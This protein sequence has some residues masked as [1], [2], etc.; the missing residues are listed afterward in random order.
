MYRFHPE[1]TFVRELIDG[2]AIGEVKM[3]RGTFDFYLNRPGDIRLSKELAGGSLMDV[4]CYPVNAARMIVGAEPVAVQGSAVWG[5]NGV[6][7]SFAG[8][9]EFPNGVLATIESSFRTELQ[10][11]GI[12]GTQGRL[13]MAEPFRMGEE[14]MTIQYDHGGIHEVREAPGA[15]EYHKM[16]EHFAD[17]VLNHKPLAYPPQSSLNQMRVI[18]ALYESARTGKK[19]ELTG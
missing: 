4:G 11:F 5:D 10:W 14:E 2:G 13:G 18:E 6:D 19:V 1:W 7:T 3:I 16:V 8:L 9:F 12:S 17:A 15:N